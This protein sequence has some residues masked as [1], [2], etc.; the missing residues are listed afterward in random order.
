M[1]RKLC[2]AALLTVVVCLGCGV[3]EH[4]HPSGAK[5]SAPMCSP[6]EWRAEGVIPSE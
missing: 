4:Q 2:C 6:T 5:E 3:P 1:D